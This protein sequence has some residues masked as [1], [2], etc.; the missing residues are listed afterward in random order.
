VAE[1][2][3]LTDA[4]IR[5]ERLTRLRAKA[6]AIGDV[7]RQKSLTLAVIAIRH[8]LHLD[9]ATP[10]PESKPGE[11]YVNDLHGWMAQCI[12][13]KDQGYLPNFSMGTDADS[14]RFVR[15]VRR[16]NRR[17]KLGQIAKVPAPMVRVLAPRAASPR[18]HRPSAPRARRTGRA[19]RDGPDDPEPGRARPTELTELQ[20]AQWLAAAAFE[21]A[22][23][24]G[25]RVFEVFLETQTIK[26]AHENARRWE[27][28]AA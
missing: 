16:L 10:I 17:W 23:E 7:E 25:D 3:Q 13:L 2:D 24:S 18:E 19:S 21:V 1:Q 12:V 22:R 6:F 14:R 11:L 9:D 15:D 5:L 8:E 4:E 27:A 20:Q 26:V 28:E